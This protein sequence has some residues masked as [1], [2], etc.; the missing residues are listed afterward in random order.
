MSE[1]S[2][3][4]ANLADTNQM[5]S[6][7]SHTLVDRPDDEILKIN[8]DA[9]EKRRGDL[10]RRLDYELHAGQNELVSYR[11]MR[12]WSDSYPAKAVAASM[13]AFQ[14]LVTS[15]FDAVRTGPKQRFRPSAENVALSTFD[16]AGAAAGSV[17]V[18][19]AVPNDRL[20]VGETELDLTFGLVEQALSARASD[21]LK[22]LA[23][24]IGIA[25]IAKAY[26]W[27]DNS[28]AFG[29]DTEI[30]WG[31]SYGE[32]QGL[33]ISQDEAKIVRELIE[34]KSDTE[35]IPIEIEGILLGHDGGTLTFHL[36]TFGERVDLRG[37]V[38]PELSKSW[39]TGRPYRARLMRTAQIKYST[40][41]ERVEWTLLALTSIDLIKDGYEHPA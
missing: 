26:A 32:L 16:F 7:M 11:I 20:L 38:S 3:I 14:D 39:M 25:S 17:I 10:V 18:S 21:D 36:E 37:S 34:N 15:V 41:E 40:G 5:V 19:L 13:S 1:L 30:K 12:D 9:I 4:V 27:A 2:D 23:D 33:I 35:S 24:K 6:E 31:K 8:L 28:V 29:L 22:L